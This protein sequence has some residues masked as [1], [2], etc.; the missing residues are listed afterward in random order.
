M[1][2]VTSGLMADG[3][4]RRQWSDDLRPL[5]CLLPSSIWQGQDPLLRYPLYFRSHT[6]TSLLCTGVL[7]IGE[8]SAYD[9]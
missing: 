8:D 9:Y 1:G 4:K 6:R 3:L 7:S 5:P 2:S